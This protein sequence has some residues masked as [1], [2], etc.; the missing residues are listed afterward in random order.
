MSEHLREMWRETAEGK[1]AA[2]SGIKV[3]A[4]TPL[5]YRG[6]FW[7]PSKRYYITD[8][9]AGEPGRW[10]TYFK[11]GPQGFKAPL[12]PDTV[13]WLDVFE[14]NAVGRQWVYI[15]FIAVR[16]AYRGRGLG[17]RLIAHLY[18]TYPQARIEWGT[19][20]GDRTPKMYQK[21]KKTHPDQ[22]GGGSPW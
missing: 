1:V 16:D 19:L 15:A 4:P 18:A 12:D 20:I 14:D 9:E 3:D 10:D 7:G 13:A 2:V 6:K 5:D 22:T 11:D 21:Y 8:S 17:S